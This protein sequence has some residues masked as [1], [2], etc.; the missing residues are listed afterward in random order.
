MVNV[1]FIIP[2][3]NAEKTIRESIYSIIDG[4][5]SSNDEILIVDDGSSDKTYSIAKTIAATYKNIHVFRHKVNRGGGAARNTAVSQS[6][7][8]LIFCLD[9][10]NILSPGSIKVLKTNI[11]DRNADIACFSNIRF[12]SDSPSNYDQTWGYHEETTSLMGQLTHSPTPGASGNYL[13]TKSSWERAGGYPD[14]A[15]ALDTWGFGFRQIAT[16]AKLLIVP[17]SFYYHR[18]G[19][20]SYWIRDSR[21]N[22]LSIVALQIVLPYLDLIDP[23]FVEYIFDK[24]N[25]YNWFNN[26]PQEEKMPKIISN[27]KISIKILGLRD[28]VSFLKRRLELFQR[29]AVN[30]CRTAKI[31]EKKFVSIH[32]T[33]EIKDY[34]II[35]AFNEPVAIGAYT[36]VNP[37]TVIYGHNKVKIGSNVMIGPHVMIASGNHDFKQVEKPMRFAGNLTKGP[38][39]IEDNVWIGAN[40]V[41]TDG[42]I[43]GHDAVIGAGTIVT[44]NVPPYAIFCGNPGKVVNSRLKKR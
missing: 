5:F 37:F 40:S 41:I 13:F 26:I 9:S 43:I 10:D 11:I 42:V 38:I 30:I 8:G 27:Q 32:R 19:H 6:K 23:M 4:N 28:V 1:S 16:G 3:F 36:Q 15:G 25:R 2:A 12:F 22:N 33:A 35:Q 39:V 7:N 29:S 18:R 44:K 17:E 24:K 21:R 31:V 20:E 34:V 14:F